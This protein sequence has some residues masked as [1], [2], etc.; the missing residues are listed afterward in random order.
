MLLWRNKK[1]SSSVLAAA[2][3]VWVFFEWLGYHFL[4]IACFLLGL[5]MALQFAWATVR[6]ASSTSSL[7]EIVFA[8]VPVG[9]ANCEGG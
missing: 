7:S 2:T 8:A 6:H 3:A 4:T 9:C 1:I 5:G